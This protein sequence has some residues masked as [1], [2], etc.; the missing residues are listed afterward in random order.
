MQYRK[1]VCI[2]LLMVSL[3]L[4]TG[5]TALGG[6]AGGEGDVMEYLI[7]VDPSSG[8]IDKQAKGEATLSGKA[9]II[10]EPIANPQDVPQLDCLPCSPFDLSNVFSVIEFSVGKQTDVYLCEGDVR[11]LNIQ[12]TDPYY[13]EWACYVDIAYDYL[14]SIPPC[15]APKAPACDGG[16]NSHIPYLLLD[17]CM[18]EVALPGALDVDSA[19]DFVWKQIDTILADDSEQ[20][21]KSI[22]EFQ[23][24][25]PVIPAP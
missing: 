3:F 13:L 6:I 24:V 4:F 10:Q 20:P 9:T 8:G 19:V 23:V 14:S 17:K 11:D 16:S 1:E 12:E 5:Q 21:N 7:G 22:F 15:P 18:R 25:I 2:F